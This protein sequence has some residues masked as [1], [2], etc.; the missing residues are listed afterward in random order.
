MLHWKFWNNWNLS[1]AFSFSKVSAAVK[2]SCFR[3]FTCIMYKFVENVWQLAKTCKISMQARLVKTLHKLWTWMWNVTKILDIPFTYNK[4]FPKS[5]KCELYDSHEVWNGVTYLGAVVDIESIMT[6]KLVISNF[7]GVTVELNC[8]CH[9][10]FSVFYTSIL[11]LILTTMATFA[12]FQPG[13]CL[14]YSADLQQ[15]VQLMLE[16]NPL[17]RTSAKELLNMPILQNWIKKVDKITNLEKSVTKTKHSADTQSTSS[18]TSDTY[19][20]SSIVSVSNVYQP[21][22]ERESLQRV[23]STLGEVIFQK[24]KYDKTR[25]QGQLKYKWQLNCMSQ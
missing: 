23:G 12:K 9:R 5:K 20:S 11:G 21:Y 18:S 16:K 22:I 13:L 3:N 15:I 8:R 6:E 2:F 1:A 19:A 14:R 10:Y 7:T 4:I 24:L 25:K 17:T